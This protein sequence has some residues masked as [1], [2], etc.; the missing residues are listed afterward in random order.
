MI[1]GYS[2]AMAR[3]SKSDKQRRAREIVARLEEAMPEAKMALDYGNELELLVSVM[4]SAQ[5]TDKLVNTVTPALFARFPDAQAYARSSPAELER[6]IQRV[7]LFRSKARNL[8][9]CMTILSEKHGGRIPRTREELNELP[10][11][12]WKTAGVVVNHAFGVPAFPVDTHV[13]RVARRL[14]LT[15]HEDPDK[16]E[17]DLQ[18][19]LPPEQWGRGHQLLIWHGRRT[20]DARKPKCDECDVAPLCPSFGKLVA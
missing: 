11:V 13:G 5:S 8:H 3:E 7:G 16:V 12:G 17:D 20:C 18:K 4:L 2:P 14:K 1:I 9:A 19:L 6:F 15:A 10:G